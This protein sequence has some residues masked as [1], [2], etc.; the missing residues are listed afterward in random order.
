MF[1]L[2]RKNTELKSRI[3]NQSGSCELLKKK[4]WKLKSFATFPEKEKY[5][6]GRERENE[7]YR[8]YYYQING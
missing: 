7:K 5:T 6:G 4:W 3:R 8:A 2:F 1:Q